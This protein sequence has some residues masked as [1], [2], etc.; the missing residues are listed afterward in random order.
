M[1]AIFT[2]AKHQPTRL[3]GCAAVGMRS[4]WKIRESHKKKWIQISSVL[5]SHL[6]SKLGLLELLEC[7]SL[8]EVITV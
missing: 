1:H 4:T 6:N 8:Q 2:A 5:C 3:E 7:K